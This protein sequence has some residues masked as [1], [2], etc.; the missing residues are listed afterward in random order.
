MKYS[1]ERL[2]QIYDRSS[3]YCHICAK[4][5]SFSNYGQTG[6]RGAWEVEH[7]NPQANGGTDRLSNLYPAHIKC[8][9]EKQ[10]HTT[11]TARAWNDR[12]RAPLSSEK[13]KETKLV[14]A[15]IG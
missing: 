3:G 10:D 2:R 14:N 4:K 6:A 1:P 11:R 9:R 7:S 12:T 13:R 8:N 5:L 15:V